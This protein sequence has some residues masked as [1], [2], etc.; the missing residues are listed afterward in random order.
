MPGRSK[1]AAA[2]RPAWQPWPPVTLRRRPRPRSHLPKR[3]HPLPGRSPHRHAPRPPGFRPRSAP[4]T[5]TPSARASR[6]VVPNASSRLG[7]TRTLAAAMSG[8]RVGN[9]PHEMDAPGRLECTCP[10]CEQPG[11]RSGAGNDAVHSGRRPRGHQPSRRSGCRCPFS[12]V[13]ADTAMT[14]QR[15]RRNLRES[16]DQSRRLRGDGLLR[17]RSPGEPAKC[18]R[19]RSPDSMRAARTAWEIA[20]TDSARRHGTA[21][22]SGRVILRVAMKGRSVNA[23]AAAASVTA[24]ESC[25]CRRSACRRRAHQLARA[26]GSRPALQRAGTTMTPLSAARRASSLPVRVTSRCSTPRR[27]E[28]PREQPGL[29][30]ASA[31]FAAGRDMKNAHSGPVRGGRANRERRGRR[32]LRA[33]RRWSADRAAEG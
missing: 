18:R 24:W 27:G 16:L 22:R 28:F 19:L 6:M 30:L 21:F 29:A 33:P 1:Y 7:T 5:G 10:Q 11:F 25:A 2:L 32:D 31:P 17:R 15:L 20:I 14:T 9:L 3:Q 13:S 4:I 23:D 12:S 8:K 26:R